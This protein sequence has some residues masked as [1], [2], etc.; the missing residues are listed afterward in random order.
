MRHLQ[1]RVVWQGSS[2]S[3]E[4]FEQVYARNINSGFRK[5]AAQAVRGLPKGAEVCSVEFWREVA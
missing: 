5:A 2:G 1:Y 3:V 4:S